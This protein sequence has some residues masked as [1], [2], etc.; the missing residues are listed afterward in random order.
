[1]SEQKTFELPGVISEARQ[2]RHRCVELPNGKRYFDFW[3]PG[4][5][6]SVRFDAE[7]YI[8][9]L[10]ESYENPEKLDYDHLCEPSTREA[11]RKNEEWHETIEEF[12]E[13]MRGAKECAVPLARAALA[14]RKPAPSETG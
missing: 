10:T 7:S 13:K 2:Q 9:V 1:M 3:M 6:R 14:S 12:V 8:R 4:G 11:A 5:N